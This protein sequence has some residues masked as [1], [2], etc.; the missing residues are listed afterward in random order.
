MNQDAL[1]EKL[2]VTRPQVSK[3]EANAHE[4]S[5]HVVER[6]ARLFGVTPAYIR[7]GDADSRMAQV[8]GLVGAGAQ[9]EAIDHPPFSY[10]EVVASWT[11]AYALRIAGLS[12][13]PIYDDGDVI[14]IRGEQRLIEE[15]FL[16]R[17]CVVETADG[18][19]YLKRV[20]RGSGPGLYTLESLNA[21]PIENVRLV[22]ARPV[23]AHLPK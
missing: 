5:D 3:Y 11:D 12:G 1:A 4:P 13:Y 19:G 6:A 10:V 7:Y 20:R 14:I 22:S 2:G 18:L 17:M 8:R 21:P 15:E 16:N 9:I 23:T